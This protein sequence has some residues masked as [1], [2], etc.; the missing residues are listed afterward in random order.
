M[1]EPK[2]ITEAIRKSF[3]I[4][5]LGIG[6]AGCNA[7]GHFAQENFSGVTFAALNTDAAALAQSRVEMKINLGARTMRGIGA[8]G[9]PARGKAAAEE[10]A[11]VIRDLCQGAD[12]VFIIAGMGGGTGTGGAPVVA[13]IARECG[14]L[15]LG[16]A[17]LP[18]D[19]EGGRRQ[20]KAK[21]GLEELKQAADGVI[22]L[23]NQKVFKLIDEKTSMVETLRITNEFIAQGVRGLWRLLARPGQINVDF[24]D[25]CSVIQAKHTE[26]T[27]AT[28]EARGENRAREVMEKLMAH[29]LID[30]GQSLA[31]TTG[32]LVCIAGGTDLSMS[33]TTRIMEQMNRQCEHAHIVMGVAIDEELSDRLCVTLLASKGGATEIATS[34]YE[35]AVASG[36]G[37]SAL[38]AAPA[39]DLPTHFVD[40]AITGRSTPRFIAP[41]PNLSQERTEQLLAQQG[42]RGR[43]VGSRMKQAQLPLEILS[44][45]RF[46]KSE[47]T[48]HQGEDLDV[49]TY[50]RRGVPLN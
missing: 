49:P 24:A 29:P 41:P 42:G 36:A 35:T 26:S 4:K 28:A 30:G 33:E 43:K 48:L 16:L 22:V 11:A 10:D 14:A 12:V 47:P 6:G 44:K 17:I 15:A 50:I 34:A 2:Q 40:P 18:F 3:T 25:L 8:G 20:T 46:E 9:E 13:R 7:I 21:A 39:A 5:V 27:L 37:Q 38:A 19:F 32:V 1:N 45:G 23:P 31:E